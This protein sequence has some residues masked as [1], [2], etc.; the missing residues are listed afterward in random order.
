MNRVN[1]KGPNMI[2]SIFAIIILISMTGCASS[3][4]PGVSGPIFRQE[5]SQHKDWPIETIES[6]NDGKVMI[7]M[8]K[9]QVFILRGSPGFWSNFLTGNDVIDIW[10]YDGILPGKNPYNAF[11]FKNDKLTSY[12][13]GGKLFTSSKTVDVRDYEISKEN[14]IK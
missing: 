10:H 4:L 13:Y 6:F 8:T 5:I 3:N 12:S 7:G 14:Y 11:S 1:K 9:E 2:K